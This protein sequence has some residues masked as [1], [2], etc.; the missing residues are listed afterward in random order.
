LIWL[1]W[2]RRI[3]CLV[4]RAVFVAHAGLRHHEGLKAFPA[5]FGSTVAVGM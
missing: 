2:R 5:Q 4:C 3:M 1:A